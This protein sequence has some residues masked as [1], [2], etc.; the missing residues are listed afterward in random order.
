MICITFTNRISR[1][2]KRQSELSSRLNSVT[3][4]SI[5]FVTGTFIIQVQSFNFGYSFG[6]F[7][8]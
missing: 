8:E 7:G 4:N 5:W 2:S 3:F 6:K 1:K